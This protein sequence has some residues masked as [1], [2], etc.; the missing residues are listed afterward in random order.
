[1]AALAVRLKNGANLAVVTDLRDR[2]AVR[3]LVFNGFASRGQSHYQSEA[4]E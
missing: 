4:E 3:F 1:M 2:L